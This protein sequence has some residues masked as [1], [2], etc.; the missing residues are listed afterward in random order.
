[1]KTETRVDGLVGRWEELREGGT[2]VTV[3]ELCAGCPELAAEVRRRIEALRAM[4]S[5]MDTREREARS[6]V[7]GRDRDRPGTGDH[8]GRPEVARAEAVY[9]VGTHHDQGGLGV[10]YI[11][12]QEEL[13]RTVALKRI[14]PDRLREA[15]KRRFLREAAL[16]ARLQH[17]GIVPIYGLGQ[18]DGGPFYTMPFIAGRTLQQAIEDLHRD[19]SSRRDP[20][21][22]GLRLRGLLQPF[23][24]ACNTVAYAHDQGVVHRDLKP[25]NVM[26]G[27]YGE[28]LVLD[29]GLAKRLGGDEAAS[30]DGGAAPPPGPSWEEVTATGEV[31]GTPLYMSPEQ[32]RGEPAGPAGD[33]FSLGLF[34]HAILT[35][36]SPFEA[37][38]ARGRGWLEAVRAAAIVPPRQRD[39]RVPRAL[40]AICLKALAPRAEDRYASARDL[41]EDVTRWL[42]DEPVAGWREPFS[43][44]ARRWARRHRT[45]V[46]AVLVALVAGLFGLGAVAA[47]QIRANDRLK[48]ALEQ[49]R[50]A[51]AKTQEA[52]DQSEES[53]AQAEAVS[54]FLV[55]AFRS[56]DPSQVDRDVKVFDVLERAGARLDQGFAGSPATKGALLDALGQ[57]YF[58]LGQYDRAAALFAKAADIR[59]AALG[60]DHIRTLGSRGN[61][62][63]A[64]AE[65]GRLTE[66]IALQEATLKLKEAKLG[67]DHLETLMTRNNLGNAYN[68]A[69]RTA[70]AI[71]THEATLKVKEAR[72]GP[73]HPET[74]ITRM[75]LA[76]AYQA[77]GRLTEAIALHELVLRMHKAKLGPDHPGT[78]L[79]RNNLAS[80]YLQA[81]RLGEAIPMF[82]AT[83]AAKERK[84][85]PDHPDTLIT[86]GNLAAT[87][88]EV[89]RVTEAIA[90]HETTLR[91]REAKLG[92]D[93]RLTLASGNNLANA[94]MAA[95]RTSAAIALH[96]ATLERREVKLGPDHLD[97]LLSRLN[98][99]V[100]YAEAGRLSEATK[101]Q[102]RALGQCEAKL[103]RDHPYTIASRNSLAVA[104]ES[105]GRWNQAESLY[106]ETLAGR[107]RIVLPDS[108][109]LAVD[110]A[111]LGHFLLERRR[112]SEAEPLL[113][114]ALAIREKATSDDWG[115]Y[116]AMSLLGAALLGRDRDAEAEPLL[117]A[118]Y[119]GMTARAARIPVPERS[120]LREA[121]E[122][123]IHLYGAWN[124]P[125]QAAD[126][127]ARARMPDL[128]ADLFA[129]R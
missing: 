14:R 59:A 40:E 28:T 124:R 24:T 44:R 57:T 69:G 99:A 19:E 84:L 21:R 102:S 23:V 63:T 9:R 10:V 104:C 66:A 120:R 8:R 76:N 79:S 94:Y 64:Y 121:A 20:G 112:W 83:L 117:V 108:P 15:A 41:A 119:E 125:E 34:L 50:Q 115:R 16:T 65:A 12:H 95:G 77:A 89:G 32:A 35:G 42:A 80:A 70:D 25:S 6:T 109:L 96:A 113:R 92:P 31:L 49:T 60:P 101:L 17:P 127:K 98:L 103:G 61:Q 122:R 56:P 43:T 22:W 116:D 100:A 48:E 37:P 53:R 67:P 46:A 29:W 129:R 36:R 73:D 110:L 68:D 62:A 97:T 118:G 111:A 58:G 90:L 45:G 11:A 1:M 3:E 38:N 74:L 13:D 86:R 72:L 18:D 114:E 91:L 2:P 107:R 126:W 128:P 5:A 7:A 27:P 106:R 54:R 75:N 26:L 4:D 33:I 88:L 55:E 52:L 93:H 85:G 82:E 51:R 47:V 39:P 30:D 123:V 78:L 71:A 81:G 105:L 87:Y